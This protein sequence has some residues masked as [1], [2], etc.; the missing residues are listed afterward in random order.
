MMKSIFKTITKAAAAAITVAGIAAAQTQLVEHTP[1]IRKPPVEIPSGSVPPACAPFQYKG[2]RAASALI[3]CY[4]SDPSNQNIAGKI[5]WS[6]NNQ[7]TPWS[8]WPAAKKQDLVLAFINVVDWYNGGMVKYSGALAPDPPQILNT[9]YLQKG[10]GGNPVVDE[11]TVAW[12]LYTGYIALNLAAE[13]YAWVPWS[14]HN[15][16]NVGLDNLFNYSNYYFQ[17]NQFGANGFC[18]AFDGM[19]ANATYTFKFFKTNNLIGANKVDTINRVLD[20]SRWNLWHSGGSGYDANLQYFNY[21]GPPPAS[22]VIEGTVTTDPATPYDWKVTPHHWTAGCGGTTIFMMNIFKAVNIPLWQTSAGGGHMTPWFVSEKL[23]LSHGDDPYSQDAKSDAPASLIAIDEA[24]YNAWFPANDPVTAA[25]NTGRRI[26]ELN[27]TY[28]S[29]WVLNLYCYDLAN[30]LDHASGKVFND[31]FKK[32]YTVSQL[33]NLGVWQK[34]D[35]KM[36]GY[37]CAM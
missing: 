23:Y 5:S 15:F 18:V 29:P 4:L 17:C 34:L 31:Y 19:P 8:Q 21:W 35:Q 24:T 37:A 28:P 26:Y 14:I 22:R 27:V 32:F 33:E 11:A 3:D 20:W 10:L 36:I 30:S 7:W 12:P 13:I 6:F 9:W 1:L 2:P 16:D 25:Q